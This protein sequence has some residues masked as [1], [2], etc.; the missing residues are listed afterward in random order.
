M[1]FYPCC[2]RIDTNDQ[3]FS[4]LFTQQSVHQQGLELNHV[5]LH[6]LSYSF[7]PMEC[8]FTFMTSTRPF[9]FFCSKTSLFYYMDPTGVPILPQA[10]A[11]LSALSTLYL[12]PS[13]L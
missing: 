2:S 8:F 3:T 12:L 4:L 6:L 5:T 13:F 11:V 7:A 1:D 10:Y 9:P